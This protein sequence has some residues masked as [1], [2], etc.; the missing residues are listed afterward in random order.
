MEVL[1]D[2][3]KGL[4]ILEPFLLQHG[5]EFD[6]Y[7]N[8]ENFVG[9]YNIATYKKKNKKFIINYLPTTGRV[10]YQIDNI[11]A[12]HDFYLDQL[13]YADKRNFQGFKKGNNLI[14]FNQILQDFD[15]LI[16]DFFK[17]ECIKLKEL[18]ELNEDILKEYNKKA[19]EEFSEQFDLIKIET[20]RNAF[21]KKDYK[22]SYGVYIKVENTNLLS[23]L[24]R[25]LI[26]NC[27]LH[28]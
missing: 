4:Q 9:I 20:A 25:K 19:H 28:I 14:G 18:S 22:K 23:D 24:D 2:L 7:E 11:K 6:N 26:E 1:I 5:F 17:G 8:E 10:D 3:T 13:G 21:S 27:K 16:N 12:Y 15:Y